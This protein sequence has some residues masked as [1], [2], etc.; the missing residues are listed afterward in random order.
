M[1]EYV[2]AGMAEDDRVARGEVGEARR[3]AK[4]SDG[5]CALQIGKR[6]V[7]LGKQSG[8]A[9]EAD[10]AAIDADWIIISGADKFG[11]GMRGAV[12]V[13]P[14]QVEQGRIEVAAVGGAEQVVAARDQ[15]RDVVDQPSLVERHQDGVAE[16]SAFDGDAKSGKVADIS[17]SAAAGLGTKNDCQRPMNIGLPCPDPP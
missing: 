13:E 3:P 17:N 16:R 2:Q 14:A 6:L 1:R 15:M 12:G 7:D 4:L 8:V 11:L 10:I 5:S 9:G